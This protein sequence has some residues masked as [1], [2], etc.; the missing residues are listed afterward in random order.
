M[1]S[2]PS[3]TWARDLC[4]LKAPPTRAES[5]SSTIWPTLC[6]LWAYSVP[7]LPR[8]TISQ[9]SVMGP[10]FWGGGSG[11]R[12]R[13]RR[14]PGPIGTRPPE[15]TPELLGSSLGGLFGS[16]A[17]GRGSLFRGLFL[18]EDFNG[19]GDVHDQGVGVGQQDGALRQHDV[20]G[21]DVLA[22]GAAFDADLDGGRQVG[23][24]GLE[25]DGGHLQVVHVARGNFA[26]DVDGDVNGDLLALADG[27]QVE[28]LDDLLDRVALDVLDQGQV[29][30][31]V[32][33]QGQQG[34]GGA[35]GQG[36]GLRRQGDV[37]RLG[38]VA[39]DDGR[40]QVGHAGAAGEALAEFGADFCCELLLR[41]GY[42]LVGYQAVGLNGVQQGRRSVYDLQRRAALR[43]E[44]QTQ[45]IT[46]TS[47]PGSD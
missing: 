27:Q 35:D 13:R 34:V 29:L 39:V 26:G 10:S 42:L 9:V 14:R 12:E 44:I 24:L 47:S 19:L 25:R 31:A 15:N 45:S 2:R 38:A 37:D 11:R 1:P 40:D 41:H 32:D 5:S 33:V 4:D 22:G 6:R 21:V 17:L 46:E 16:G 3:R 36:G 23:C 20:G 8:P 18:F 43:K 30:L 7:G 28:V